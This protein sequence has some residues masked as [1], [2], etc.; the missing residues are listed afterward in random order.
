MGETLNQ[1]V[2]KPSLP[3]EI[4][5][6][7]WWIYPRSVVSIPDFVFSSLMDLVFD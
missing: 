6:G 3:S 2:F 1:C 4:Q 7:D 5:I